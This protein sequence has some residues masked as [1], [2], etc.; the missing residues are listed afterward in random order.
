MVD[1][2]LLKTM[3]LSRES[4]ALR[5]SYAVFKRGVDPDA[6]VTVLYSRL[7]LTIEEKRK[8]THRM[9]TTDQQLDTVLEC[10]ES[11]VSTDP[12]VF[13]VVVEALLKE[14]ALEAVGRKMQCES[15]GY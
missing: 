14:S 11:R 4:R 1:S 7:L 3:E 10:L 5:K 9:L 2:F 13:H 15:V 8:A 6:I 12:S